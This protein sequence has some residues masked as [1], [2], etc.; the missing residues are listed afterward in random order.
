M[1]TQND[2]NENGWMRDENLIKYI[3]QA[4]DSDD[5]QDF[6]MTVTV[7]PHGSYPT[8]H[9]IDN[10]T[11]TVSGTSTDGAN[12]AWEY[13]VNQLHEEDQFVSDLIDTLNKRGEPTVVLF[14]GDHL[15]TMGLQDS[16]LK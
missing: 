10:P 9:V 15:P 11:I 6:V 8:E 12:A 14:Y 3:T 2:V 4:L 13:Y 16:D 1:D 5:N 7:Q